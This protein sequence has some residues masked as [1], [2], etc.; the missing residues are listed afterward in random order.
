V[1]QSV[2]ADVMQQ[3]PVGL[4]VRQSG[5][6]VD[7][8]CRQQGLIADLSPDT[9]TI[10]TGDCGGLHQ[11]RIGG[12]RACVRVCVHTSSENVSGPR[13]SKLVRTELCEVHI[14]AVSK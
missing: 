8:E 12:R 1:A 6:D 9:Y 14:C 10:L 11:C 2:V 13:Q 7:T 4:V 3:G 5:K